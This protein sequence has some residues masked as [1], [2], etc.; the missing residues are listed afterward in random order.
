MST[1]QIS[2]VN[3]VSWLSDEWVMDSKVYGRPD[4]DGISDF[5]RVLSGLD[6]LSKEE[7]ENSL[8]LRLGDSKTVQPL[9]RLSD[10]VL[11][12]PDLGWSLRREP[13]SKTLN[14]LNSRFGINRLAF[15]RRTV[16]CPN[17][18]NDMYHVMCL[19]LAGPVGHRYWY[20]GVVSLN[21]PLESEDDITHIMA[22]RP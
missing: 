8:F 7:A 4:Y 2:P 14:L 1:L 19:Y 13:N 10:L 11:A 5:V 22:F 15:L 21:Y 9:D 12:D 6:D 3:P 18:P 16:C 20:T 17:R